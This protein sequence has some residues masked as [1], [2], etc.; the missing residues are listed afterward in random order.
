MR[1]SSRSAPLQV[2]TRRAQ[3][4]CTGAASG[5]RARLSTLQPGGWEAYL[6]F[7]LEGAGRACDAEGEL[8]IRHEDTVVVTEN[9]RENLAPKWSGTAEEPA[10]V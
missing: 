10:V 2:R 6:A 8:G 1:C 4:R 7:T 5:S 9:G 3:T